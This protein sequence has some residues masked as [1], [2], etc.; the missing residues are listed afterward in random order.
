MRPAADDPV[1]VPRPPPTRD[2]KVPM[3]C[4]GD[5]LM[6]WD[7][8]SSYSKLLNLSPFSLDDFEKAIC[9]KDSNIVLI[10]ESYSALLRLLIKDGGDYFIALQKKKRKPKVQFMTSL[11]S[12]AFYLLEWTGEDG[13]CLTSQSNTF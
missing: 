3:E 7:F 13:I 9:Y 6:I 5:L 10:V 12:N 2:F 11:Y 8:C 1:L 4:V